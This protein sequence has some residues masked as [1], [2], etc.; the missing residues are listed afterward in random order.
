MRS[1]SVAGGRRLCL[2]SVRPK[3]LCRSSI[4]ACKV[5][6]PTKAEGRLQQT[7]TQDGLQARAL[8]RRSCRPRHASPRGVA[9]RSAFGCPP[10]SYASSSCAPPSSTARRSPCSRQAK[11]LGARSGRSRSV[12]TKP[13][14]VP[15]NSFRKRSP[16]ALLSRCSNL[17]RRTTTPRLNPC[18]S[19]SLRSHPSSSL[20]AA[21]AYSSAWTA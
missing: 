2:F 10:S 20:R 15:S 7:N 5:F 9:K 16:C 19:C 17:I 21:D 1:A 12:L 14:C 4:R 3:Q 18:S 6:P 13:E 8:A 11:A